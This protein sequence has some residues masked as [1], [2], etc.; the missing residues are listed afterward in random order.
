MVPIFIEIHLFIYKRMYQVT[1]FSKVIYKCVI[2]LLRMHN[3]A[4][5]AEYYKEEVKIA[6]EYA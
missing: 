3:D 2:G 1:F 5:G 4:S 6:F